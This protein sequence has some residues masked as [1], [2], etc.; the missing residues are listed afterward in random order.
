MALFNEGQLKVIRFED[1]INS[2]KALKV[3]D[4][5]INSIQY[6]T[7]TIYSRTLNEYFEISDNNLF[8]LMNISNVNNNY[9]IGFFRPLK[10]KNKIYLLKE[11]S[12]EYIAAA[13]NSIIKKPTL[14][15]G[16]KYRL[17]VNG[18]PNIF[19]KN[20]NYEV[21]ETNV[22]LVWTYL[23][24]FFYTRNHYYL[25]NKQFDFGKYVS[26]KHVFLVNSKLVEFARREHFTL[27]EKVGVDTNYEDKSISTN[28]FNEDVF[29]LVKDKFENQEKY[30][31]RSLG[32]KLKY[33]DFDLYF[34]SIKE[35][36]ILIKNNNLLVLEKIKKLLLA[37]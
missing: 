9:L 16:D 33:I 34:T 31:N 2:K 25:S 10:F 36:E 37:D 29:A 21:E 27:I 1:I 35:Q 32:D 11:D 3:N 6:Q 22:S 5:K 28:K 8:E 18:Q 14:K 12:P 20:R 13:S 30:I 19:G 4:W 24:S 17:K 26:L 15:H 7:A 23:G